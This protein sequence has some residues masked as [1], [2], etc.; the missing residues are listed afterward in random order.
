MSDVA[1]KVAKAKKQ[2][3]ELKKQVPANDRKT[4]GELDAGAEMGVARRVEYY[5]QVVNLIVGW[6][7]NDLVKP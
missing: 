3:E 7:S 1:D 6:L 5:N 2:V 4:R